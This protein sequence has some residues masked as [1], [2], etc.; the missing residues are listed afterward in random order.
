MRPF[1]VLLRLAVLCSILSLVPG[2]NALERWFM[3]NQN[4][5]VDQN[6][7]NLV[8][9]MQRAAGAGYTHMLLGD[10]KFCRLATMD[11]HYFRNVATIKQ[12]RSTWGWKL[13]QRCFRL[14]TRTTCSSTIPI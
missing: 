6:I 5:W 14:V 9:L 4:L 8:T 3:V 13:C 2:S 10:S 12:R 11:A 7:T 1:S